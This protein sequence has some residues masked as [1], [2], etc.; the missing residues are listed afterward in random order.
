MIEEIIAL[1]DIK[2]SIVE[3]ENTKITQPEYS[4]FVLT[5]N[6]IWFE[7]NLIDLNSFIGIC[8][9]MNLNFYKEG[10]SMKKVEGF[11][12]YYGLQDWWLSSFTDQEREYIDDSYQPMGMQP[13]S[14]TRGNISEYGLPVTEFLN[15]L[16]TW[17]RRSKDLSISE[18]IHRLII[19]EGKKQ[20]IVKAGYYNGRH[21]TTW[22]R[23]FE[24]LKK[25]GN[26]TELEKLLL[27][28]VKA[29]EAESAVNGMGVAPAYYNELAILYRKQKD[30]SKEVS[31]LERFEKQ[32]H[33]QGAI[34]GKLHER[35]EKAKELVSK[36]TG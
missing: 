29:T 1:L 36:K 30:F 18:R 11:I 17:F 5:Y 33:T 19:E 21:F 25:S 31:I 7:G 3:G 26:N 20:P 2:N 32:K 24:N 23:D 16:N 10:K 12:A 9:I 6:D 8:L 15:G 13:H 34:P 22:V 27:E 28:L 4:I 14:L 35:L